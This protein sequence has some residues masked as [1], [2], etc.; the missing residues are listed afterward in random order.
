MVLTRLLEVQV[1]FQYFSIGLQCKGHDSDLTSG[2]RSKILRYTNDTYCRYCFED[3]MRGNNFV[4]NSSSDVFANF[5][6]VG[7]TNPL[8]LPDLT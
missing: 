1:A 3:L 5:S 2:H 6:E 4:K 8:W 7:S